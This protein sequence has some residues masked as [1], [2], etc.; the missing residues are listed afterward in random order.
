MA[1]F[2]FTAWPYAGCLYP[3]IAVAHA[4]AGRGHSV[5]FYTGNRACPLVSSQPFLH[6]PFNPWL[7]QQVDTLLLS[8]S[9]M[10]AGWP[11]PWRRVGLLRQFLVDTVPSQVTDLNRIVD[12]WQPEVIVTEPAM[13]APFLILQE[14]RQIPVTVLEYSFCMLPG[15][16]APPSGLGWP[17]PRG[18]SGRL[19]TRFGEH[20]VHMFTAGLR[21]AASEVRRQHGLSPLKPSIAALLRR[22]PLILVP[23][24]PEFDYERRDLPSSVRYVGPCHWYPSEL[25]TTLPALQRD[26]PVVHVTE[27]TL[28]VANP[29]VLDAAARGLAELPLQVIIAT[30]KQR[31]LAAVDLGRLA[32]NV[33]VTPWVSYRELLP[34]TDLVVTIGGGGTVLAALSAG[35]PMV[36][37][38]MMWDHVDNAERV[39]ANGAGV[40]LSPRRCTPER[41]RAAVQRVLE[42]PSYR[43]NAR[44][45][46]AAL[47]A[48]PGPGGAAQLLAQLCSH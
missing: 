36:V 20:L 12:E 28:Y 30:G 2:L 33:V 34:Q 3:Q 32:S 15:P 37:V 13:Y 22:L 23:S 9:G 40:R 42:N 41:L 10:C 44:R 1:K 6:F 47:N 19:R 35:V 48:Q 27:G 17:P 16:D 21:R 29:C 25:N 11:Q 45:L 5:A 4:L 26:R 14:T 18:W 31:S 46:G 43:Q 8:P 38:P 24:C 7:E 39:V